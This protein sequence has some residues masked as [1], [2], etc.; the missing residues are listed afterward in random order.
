MIEQD[1]SGGTLLIV[2]DKYAIH[3]AFGSGAGGKLLSRNTVASYFGNTKNYYLDSF[4]PLRVQCGRKLLAMASTLKNH[5]QNRAVGVSGTC[6]SCQRRA[7]A[8]EQRGA[9]WLS[10][11]ENYREGSRPAPT[12]GRSRTFELHVWAEEQ[13]ASECEEDD[14]VAC[15]A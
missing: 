9:S 1:A 12:A 6:W 14:G 13:E 2:L 4:E 8:V 11:A 7:G 3:L 5:T 15:S 10:A